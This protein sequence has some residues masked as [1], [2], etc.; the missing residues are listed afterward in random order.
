MRGPLN[1]KLFKNMSHAPRPCVAARS[2]RDAAWRR[3]EMTATR[4]RPDPTVLQVQGS[5]EQSPRKTPRSVAA[6][7]VFGTSGSRTRSLT[8]MFAR[9]FAAGIEQLVVEQLTSVQ[10]LPPSEVLKM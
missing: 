8:G 2:M 7:R 1:G 5:A 3:N 6:Y 10:L 9:S 4:G